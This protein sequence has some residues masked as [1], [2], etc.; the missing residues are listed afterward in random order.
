M[1]KALTE[2]ILLLGIDGLDPRLTRKYV[3]EGKMPNT[4]KYLERGAAREDLVLL[5]GHPTVTPPMWTTLACGC[6]A[7]V[8]GITGFFR[9][10]KTDLD[11]IE[12]N[13]NSKL[14]QAEPLWNVFVEAG[15]KT[16]V[17][18][19]PGSSWPPTSDSSNLM[20]VDGTS[21]GAVCSAVSQVD[22]EFL[23]GANKDFQTVSFKPK[24]AIDA[25]APCVIEDLDLNEEN[26]SDQ[27][28]S[29]GKNLAV[30]FMEESDKTSSFSENALDLVQSPIRQASGWTDAPANAKEFTL[31]LSQGLIRRPGLIL[32]DEQGKYTKVAL[33][34]SKKEV[35]PIVVLKPQIIARQ[36]VDEAIKGDKK[37]R[38]SRNFK[39]L[40]LD[41]NGD[42]LS[43]Y[44]STAV[45]IDNDSVFH[46]KSIYQEITENVG[47]PTPTS[48][49][50]NQNKILIT[51]CML[52]CW[53]AS[54]DWQA[55]AILY[56]IEEKKL[57]V[58]FSHFHSV[59]MQGHM[60]VRHLAGR[61]FNRLPIEEYYKF[62]EDI[63]VQADYYLGK[64]IHLL[65][66]DWTICIFSDHG[67]IAPEHD[68][69]FLGDPGGVNVRVMQQL[70]FT[71][72]K[73]DENGND[74]PE[75]DWAQTRAVAVREQHIYLNLKGKYATGIV[76]PADQYELEEEIMTALYGYRDPQTGHRVVAVALRNKDA[77]L[78]GQGGPEA[79]DICYWVAEGYNYDH[80]DSLSTFIGEA[81]TAV[82]PMFIAS[83]C[84]V[85]QGFYTDRIIRQVDF[86]P[87][88]AALGGVRMPA[89]CEGAPVYQILAE[90]F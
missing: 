17:W 46:P 72:L 40:N 82:S 73:T 31:L 71:V 88:V 8:H 78:L 11:V 90:E 59:D 70:G 52:D 61:E 51:E 58:V 30:F 37:Y 77:V 41:E 26:V 25:A 43:L 80:A 21:P 23:L 20:V 67:L 56:L 28:A 36:V 64:F 54:A 44:I 79:G 62:L 76:D 7:N 55:A 13:L 35:E 85:K 81:S 65:D 74:L 16:L 50:G 63:Y 45:D 5:G 60:F 29:A 32:P 15:K 18:H 6:Y 33:Y 27:D 24:A 47:Y 19:W 69:Q 42:K 22:E 89:Q 57:D 53:F 87:T 10:S 83:G 49:I 14:C 39:V 75:I 4:K 3:D 34:K 1:R 86:A 12:Y 9:Q 66:Q 38:A 2:K 68:T 84:G 48:M